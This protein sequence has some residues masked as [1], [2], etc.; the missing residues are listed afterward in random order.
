MKSLRNCKRDKGIN[1]AR[2]HISNKIE[3]KNV[4][5]FLMCFYIIIMRNG[6]EVISVYKLIE[7]FD[8]VIYM[9]N[10]SAMYAA[11]TAQK[12]K[13]SSIQTDLFF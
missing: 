10:K 1:V 7:I 12:E 6:K 8:D 3:P 9:V 5:V 13:R 11:K 4:G 2:L